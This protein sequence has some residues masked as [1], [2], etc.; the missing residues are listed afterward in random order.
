MLS[1]CIVHGLQ[2]RDHGIP[3]DTGRRTERCHL[4]WLQ[5]QPFG[6]YAAICRHFDG[7][8]ELYGEFG[9]LIG[10]DRCRLLDRG[11]GE[12]RCRFFSGNVCHLLCQSS[13][14]AWILTGYLCVSIGSQRWAN[15]KKYSS[16]RPACMFWAPH[17]TISSARVNGRTGTIRPTMSRL[18]TA[19]PRINR[20]ARTQWRKRM[21]LM[22]LCTR[23]QYCSKR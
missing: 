1:H 5:D 4:F 12:W 18:R 3:V 11:K 8:H 9:R 2:S 10:T 21:P 13:L 17:S 6:Y 7:L 16:L 20:M 15:G 19:R 22:R 23:R 14:P